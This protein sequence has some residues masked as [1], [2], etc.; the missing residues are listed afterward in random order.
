MPP[1]A[2]VTLPALR[3]V[4]RAAPSTEA[5]VKPGAANGKPAGANAHSVAAQI[6]SPAR[7]EATKARAAKTP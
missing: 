6:G 7:N 3:N 4:S 1:K 5:H 2:N